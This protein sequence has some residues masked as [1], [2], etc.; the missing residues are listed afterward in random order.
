MRAQAL[1]GEGKPREETGLAITKTLLAVK[2]SGQAD[3]AETLLHQPTR[4]AAIRA[5]ATAVNAADTIATARGF[6][7]KAAE[8]YWTA[9][10]G[11]VEMEFTGKRAATLPA[12]W[13]VFIGRESRI[14]R[15]PRRATEPINALLNY[16]YRVAESACVSACRAYG[17]DPGMGISH[18]D[19]DGRDSF[20]LDLLKAVR[21]TVDPRRRLHPDPRRHVPS[22]G[23][24][25]PRD[26]RAALRLVRRRSPAR[27]PRAPYAGRHR[28]RRRTRH[29]PPDRSHRPQP[30]HRS[31]RPPPH[32]R[33]A[34]RTARQ[35]EQARA[36]DGRGN[37]PNRGVARGT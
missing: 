27:C 30:A 37:V 1:C 29:T 26:R 15:S 12:E 31:A 21:P 23:A 34:S 9:W 5:C 17:I 14:G 18:A 20:A 33:T 13:S 25:H 35:H 2:L 6:E 16:A 32:H 28:N 10:T 36:C 22:A 24:P 4:A 11:T 19:K 3:I 8:E 7:G